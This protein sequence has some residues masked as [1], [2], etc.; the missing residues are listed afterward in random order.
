MLFLNLYAGNSGYC[1]AGFREGLPLM[2]DDELHTIARSAATKTFVNIFGWC[3]AKAGR[4][5]AVKRTGSNE[6]GSC[7]FKLYKP[8]DNILY[9]NISNLVDE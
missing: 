5:F 2:L 7:F 6:A 4:F 3:N 9:G 8:T 1:F